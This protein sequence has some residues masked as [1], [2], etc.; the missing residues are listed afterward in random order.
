MSFYYYLSF[1]IVVLALFF[2]LYLHACISVVDLKERYKLIFAFDPEKRALLLRTEKKKKKYGVLLCIFTPLAFLAL[3]FLLP[4]D[5]SEGKKSFEM[6]DWQASINLLTKVSESDSKYPDAQKMLII[7][8]T[9]L[10]NKHFE[11]GKSAYDAKNW[12]GVM[13]WLYSFPSDHIHSQEASKMLEEATKAYEIER[14]EAQKAEILARLPNC[15]SVDAEFDVMN[16]VRNAPL[17]RVYGLEILKIKNAQVVSEREG[18]RFCRGVAFMNNG[19]NYG[20]S[21]SFYFDDDG[22]PMVRAN[23]MGL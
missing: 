6:E 8:K 7:A 1:T 2:L 19:N 23:V 3:L 4:T 16:A 11:E 13:M 22:A 10:V 20:V 5:F 18:V 9:N 12:S 15:D 17:G 21:Y 14:V